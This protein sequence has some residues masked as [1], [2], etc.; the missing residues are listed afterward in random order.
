M[1]R[2]STADGSCN[3][4]KA[5][6][7]SPA[8]RGFLSGTISP[9]SMFMMVLLMRDRQRVMSRRTSADRVYKWLAC[10]PDGTCLTVE[11]P[12]RCQGRCWRSHNWA[13]GK[14]KNDSCAATRTSVY[15]DDFYTHPYLINHLDKIIHKKRRS[16][17]NANKKC[18]MKTN[19]GREDNINTTI[20]QHQQQVPDSR[21]TRPNKE[22][23]SRG[24][25]RSLKH[26]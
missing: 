22:T 6:L 16:I 26:K 11:V 3:S 2:G 10:L 8:G 15:V 24:S 1:N 25:F 23:C 4:T 14:Q 18:A 5:T 9:R 20:W 17:P 19:S 21:T 13:E 12:I 7:Q